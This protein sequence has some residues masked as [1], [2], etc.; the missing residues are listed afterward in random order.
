MYKPTLYIIR[1]L[2]E[3]EIYFNLEYTFHA[4]KIEL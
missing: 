1:G 4:V 2:A 3:L